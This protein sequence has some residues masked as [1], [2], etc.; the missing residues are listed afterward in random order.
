MSFQQ[1][2]SSGFPSESA[3]EKFPGAWVV[4]R[5]FC[6]PVKEPW[7][8][9]PYD[10]CRPLYFHGPDTEELSPLY[11]TKSRLKRWK[12]DDFD[13]SLPSWIATLNNEYILD[14]EYKDG[15]TREKTTLELSSTH[16][17]AKSLI[18]L[19]LRHAWFDRMLSELESS[20]DMKKKQLRCQLIVEL[21]RTP[22]STL[23]VQKHL[24][25]GLRLEI[26]LRAIAESVECNYTRMWMLH[27]MACGAGNGHNTRVIRDMED[28]LLESVQKGMS[29]KAV[30]GAFPTYAFAEYLKLMRNTGSEV[31]GLYRRMNRGLSR[32]CVYSGAMFF[33]LMVGSFC[34]IAARLRKMWR[35]CLQR[36]SRNHTDRHET[37]M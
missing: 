31:D 30:K 18:H 2:E 11:F 27:L 4:L 1:P 8:T 26:V 23:F 14:A 9:L 29:T 3:D 7:R 35:H 37:K 17:F 20:D 15:I 13:S 25:S 12:F 24:R 33:S 6:Y 5:G 19:D 36:S 32:C 34:S 10:I 22:V 28:V 21:L 16:V